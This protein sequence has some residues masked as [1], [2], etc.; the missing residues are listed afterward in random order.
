MAEGLTYEKAKAEYLK[1]FYS[2]MA[3]TVLTVFA[4][5]L[6]FHGWVGIIVGL[7]IA[8]VKT[9]LV[10]YVFMHLKFDSPYLRIFIAVPLFL[11]FVMI[12]AFRVLGI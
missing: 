10:M 7:L 5:M 6:P 8:A 9:A 12:F 3:F 11:M 1:V 4:A 2:L